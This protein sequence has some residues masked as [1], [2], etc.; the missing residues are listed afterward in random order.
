M[1]HDKGVTPLPCENE[2][3]EKRVSEKLKESKSLSA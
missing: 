1:E 2:P 3:E